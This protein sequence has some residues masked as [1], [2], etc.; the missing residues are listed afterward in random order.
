[1]PSE[2]PKELIKVVINEMALLLDSKNHPHDDTL[3][4]LTVLG[5]DTQ[6]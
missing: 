3:W 2:L 4:Q 6:L 1:M 5:A